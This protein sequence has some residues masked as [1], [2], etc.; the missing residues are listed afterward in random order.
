M[1]L[2]PFLH[3]GR[4]LGRGGVIEM[5]SMKGKLRYACDVDED[6]TWLSN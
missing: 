3:L 4:S 1:F 2:N 5:K 6:S